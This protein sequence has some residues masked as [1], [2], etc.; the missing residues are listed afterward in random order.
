[1]PYERPR[2]RGSAM[3]PRPPGWRPPPHLRRPLPGGEEGSVVAA[4][5]TAIALVLVAA[6]AMGSLSK[7]GDGPRIPAKEALVEPASPTPL[8]VDEMTEAFLWAWNDGRAEFV[9][10]DIQRVMGCA[11]I[12]MLHAEIDM[13]AVGAAEAFDDD[14]R[15]LLRRH[16]R[17]DGFLIGEAERPRRPHGVER[18][19]IAWRCASG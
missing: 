7:E 16:D 9:R 13:G 4:S 1:M 2:M 12:T 3:L 15:R 18:L 17:A 8:A 11:P 5:V 14:H 10:Q 19:T 6:F